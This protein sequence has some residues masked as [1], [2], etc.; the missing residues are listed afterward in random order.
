MSEGR[1]YLVGAGPGDPGLITVRGRELLAR[2]DVVVYDHLV[3][4]RLLSSAR[5]DAELI[6]VGK[7]AGRHTLAQEEIS[8]LL[9]AR[10]AGGAAVVRLKGGDPFV[11]GRGG[12]E[13]LA[14]V[15]AGIGFEVVPGV[16]A[17]VAAPACAG[18]PAT[19]RN[20]ACGL[21]LVTG[22][23]APDKPGA[24]LD[25]GA[26][27]RWRGTLVFY[28]GVANLP[29]ICRSLTEHGLSGETPAAIVQWGTTARQKVLVG[30]VGS[31]PAR[32]AEAGLGP[33]AVIVI[34]EV[35]RLR[36]KL[37]W[38]ERRALFGRRIVVT[39]AR[40]QASALVERL[41]GL[42][43]E[44][45]EVPTI[46]IEPLADT[47]PLDEAAAD[48]AACDWIVFTSANGVDAYFAALARAGR[49]A[50]ALS[51]NRVCVIGPATAERLGRFGLRADLQPPKFVSSAIVE[52]LAAAADLAGLRV[53]CC[54]ADIA[55]PDLVEA[56][57]ARGAVVRDVAAYRTV[58]DDS[59]AERAGELLA[60]DEVD[61]ITFTSSSTVSNFFAAVD[62]EAVRRCRAKPASIGPS[63]SA[64][65]RRL[66]LAPAVQADVHT[67]DGLVEAILAAE[68]EAPNRDVSRLE[69]RPGGPRP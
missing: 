7:Q 41:E 39:R 65:L 67:I 3:S 59:G 6:Y 10:A 45:I 36:E 32:A 8:A 68:K 1:V 62:C 14:L 31:L 23:E 12:E 24:D 19:H 64:A 61:W 26:L 30:T 13:A 27:A 51:A 5:A 49:D 69:P 11:F 34:G 33:P 50:R 55:P 43:A 28:M 44:V 15:E 35:V 40:A 48:P 37:A 54:R 22:H 63:T 60:A 47:G 53:L 25:F 4:P 57:A 38:F 2:A 42:G 66:G 16:T 9:V 18:I 58:C 29:T 20:L 52:A 56:L 46:R 21:G 17:G